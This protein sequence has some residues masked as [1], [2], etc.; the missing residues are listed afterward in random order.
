MTPGMQ[1][2]FYERRDEEMTVQYSRNIDYPAH[3]HECLELFYVR[4]GGS[5]VTVGEQSALM[6]TGDLALIFS[7]VIHSYLSRPQS[8]EVSDSLLLIVPLSLTGEYR[9]TLAETAPEN[10]FLPAGRLHPDVSYAFSSIAREEERNP[11][12]ERALVQLILSRTLPLLHLRK[13]AAEPTLVYQIVS[14]LAASY[15]EPV[16]LDSLA[17]KLGV[18]RYTLSRTFSQKLGCGFPEYLNRL[19]L[20][21]AESLL[22]NTDR[23]ITE[24]S[25]HC[26][27]E[28]P[29]TFN[30][31]FLKCR[32]ISP[33]DFR[34][35]ASEPA[36]GTANCQ[37]N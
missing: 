31:A 6:E 20:S 21:E 27:F 28:T 12:A 5:R 37:I 3:F 32:G 4:S 36:D 8:E 13:G 17:L 16:T 23:P 18:S 15:R 7:N 30:R 25:Y 22:L 11:R 9:Q 24:I 33:R 14:Q 26:G 10:P 2:A 19:R 35:L 34:R 29:R 1:E